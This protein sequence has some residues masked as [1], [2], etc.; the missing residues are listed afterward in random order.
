MTALIRSLPKQLRVN[1]VPAPDVARRF[2]E[3]V[4]PGEE[5]LLDALSRYLR[6]LTGV[7]VPRDAW[8]LDKVPAHL[9]P[10]FRV[11]RRAGRRGRRGQ[12]P[13]GAQGAA[14]AVLRPGDARRSA[15][16]SGVERDRADRRGPSGP[17]SRR[18]PRRGPATR[19][20]ATR[21]WSTRAARSGCGSPPRP[22][23]RR[24]STGSAYAACCCSPSPS[25]GRRAGRR[26]RQHRQARPRRLAVPERPRA[27][28]GL[29]RRGRR[30]ARRPGAAGPRPGR[31][32]RAGRRAR[33]PSCPSGPPR[34][35]H[36]V[37]RV[38]AEWR[39]VDKALHGRVEMALLPAMTDLRGQLARLVHDGFVGEAGTTAL[40]EYP[41]YLQAMTARIER[42][43]E[44][45]PRPRADGPRRGAPAGLAAPG[46]R[47]AGRATAGRPAA[48]GALDARGVPRQ[49]LGPAAR[50]RP[51]GLGRADPQGARA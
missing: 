8:D 39:P 41:R 46:R 12:G 36:Q 5:P 44:P 9:R 3:A 18:S 35:L 7:H 11:A 21:R 43:G 49:P 30:G 20:T 2:L 51:A 48:P 13:R 26:A 6:S 34:V 24:P 47:A 23:S 32:R 29:R 38:L 33:G 22:R 16:E 31:L 37:L 45:A 14:A 1:F 28:R 17:S 27:H 10:T 25:P 50:H 19:C 4:P 40:R 42:L 15:E